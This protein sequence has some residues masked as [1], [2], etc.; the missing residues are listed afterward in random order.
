LIATSWLA[1]SIG[2][3]GKDADQLAEVE[4]GPG[5]CYPAE[6]AVP[7]LPACSLRRLATSSPFC[8]GDGLCPPAWGPDVTPTS[9]LQAQ[10]TL[11]P[12]SQC[13]GS[14]STAQVMQRVGHGWDC[15]ISA[16][17]TD[18][19]TSMLS[20]YVLLA[21]TSGSCRVAAA[22]SQHSLEGGLRGVSARASR[23]GGHVQG[24]L[25]SAHLSP[26]SVCSCSLQQQ[27]TFWSPVRWQCAKGAGLPCFTGFASQA[28]S[29]AP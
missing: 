25:L 13:R 22:C 23:E 14:T 15:S 29:T 21:D 28:F 1:H 9:I 20:G 27:T 17:G 2:S 16:C 11:Q 26:S 18:K 8:A 24:L 6:I 7:V 3:S 12:L 5:Y 4:L 19:L 10:G